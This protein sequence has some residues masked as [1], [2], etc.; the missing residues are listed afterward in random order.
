MNKNW[1]NNAMVAGL[2]FILANPVFASE[3]TVIDDCNCDYEISSTQ[4]KTKVESFM[5]VHLTKTYKSDD[6][7]QTSFDRH[8]VL[9][10]A[11]FEDVYVKYENNFVKSIK[12]RT[13]NALFLSEDGYQKAMELFVLISK[14]IN[15]KYSV[16]NNFSS[17]K[18]ISKNNVTQ[19]F[20]FSHYTL[21]LKL[22][23]QNFEKLGGKYSLISFSFENND[24]YPHKNDDEIIK[25][26]NLF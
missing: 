16:F 15:K 1:K 6:F 13:K 3:K 10:N 4:S 18:S 26:L 20:H 25:T 24:S 5:S 22:K 21:I 12:G 7:D 9:D 2:A 14:N 23:E 19:V 17:Q 8:I 11:Y